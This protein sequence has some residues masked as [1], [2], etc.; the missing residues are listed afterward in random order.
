[1]TRQPENSSGDLS[2]SLRTKLQAFTDG[3][4]PEEHAQVG[5]LRTAD[6]T[7]MLSPLPE[8]KAGRAVEAL[9]TE[10]EAQLRLLLERAGVG[11]AAGEETD[12]R[13]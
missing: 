5:A 3:L 13:G 11:A 10:D 6:V 9:T 1:M 12:T 2:P 8:A 7:G 4:T